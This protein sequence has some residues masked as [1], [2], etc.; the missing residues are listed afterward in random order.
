MKTY[1]VTGGAQGIG[2]AIA[3]KLLAESATVY[4]IDKQSTEFIETQTQANPQTFHFF[5]QDIADRAGLQAVLEKMSDVTF[6]GIVNNAGEVYLEKWDA[7]TIANW[8]RTMSVN[9]TA[10]MHIVHNL[11]SQL[12]KGGAVVNIA[13]SDANVAAFDA[14]AYAASKA[15][16]MSLTKSLA[17]NLGQ[18]MVRVNAIAPG[19]V[20]TEMTKDTMPAEARELVPMKRN[21]T[22]EQIANVVTFLLS[23]QAAAIN[24]TTVMADD[25]LSIIDYSLWAEAQPDYDA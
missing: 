15:A 4:V 17:V 22:G 3:E 11:R 25:G 7:F 1:L 16:L 8:D 19:W 6:D 18:S 10:P 12:A 2:R 9:V 24:G 14:I 13:S 23:D 21:A 20:A 5:L